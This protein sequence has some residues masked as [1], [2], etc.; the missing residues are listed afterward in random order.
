M[1][2][3]I[4]PGHALGGRPDPGAVNLE[5]NI[6]EAEVNARIA[7]NCC[8]ALE[9]YG[10]STKTVQSHNLRGEAPAYP[11]VTA[12]ANNW[13]ADVFLSIHA[14]A[15]GGRGCETYA[16]SECSWG[17]GLAT[18][19]QA[20]VHR[21]VSR[22]DKTFPDRGVKVNPDFT[23]LRRTAM[24]AILVETA[25]LD[26]DEDIRLL[27][28]YPAVFGQAIASGVDQFLRAHITPEGELIYEEDEPAPMLWRYVPA[29]I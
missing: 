6:T 7:Q 29:H 13:P 19:V 20:S 23:V 5:H 11:N 26:N 24:P 15:G 14:N 21:A 12:L 2:I 28:D 3:F 4:N 27:L 17:H 10:H 8:I 9:R 16:F 1:R 18:I 25:F 22:L